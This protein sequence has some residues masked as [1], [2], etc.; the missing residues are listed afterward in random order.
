MDAV[1][2]PTQ[3][4]RAV[5]VIIINM[6]IAATDGVSFRGEHTIQLM[7]GRSHELPG[8][9]QHQASLRQ[10]VHMGSDTKHPRDKPYMQD[11]TYMGS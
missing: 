7:V 10:A 4:Q 2:D 3:D 11:T 5:I 9:V 1:K 6:C 8:G